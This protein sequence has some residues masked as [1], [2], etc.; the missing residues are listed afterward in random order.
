MAQSIKK[1]QILGFM[2]NTNIDAKEHNAAFIYI[3]VDFM[4]VL[5]KEETIAKATL[6]WQCQFGI[7]YIIGNILLAIFSKRL[8]RMLCLDL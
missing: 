6:N 7:P 2:T 1:G 8:K 4:A 5:W 3:Q